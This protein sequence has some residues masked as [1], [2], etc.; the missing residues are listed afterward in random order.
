M[1]IIGCDL[2]SRQQT[3]AMLDTTTGEIEKTAFR[4]VV[5]RLK[6]SSGDPL[7]FP[8]ATRPRT[9]RLT[10]SATPRTLNLAFS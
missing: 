6:W 2:H 3:L 7:G 9:A 5:G 8:F 10:H 4:V 1:R